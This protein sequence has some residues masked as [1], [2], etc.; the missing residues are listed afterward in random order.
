MVSNACVVK[1]RR[2]CL[3]PVPRLKISTGESRWELYVLANSLTD[4]AGFV[5]VSLGIV[6][7]EVLHQL[8]LQLL[9]GLKRGFIQEVFIEG[10]P[11]PPKSSQF[12]KCRPS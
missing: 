4:C 3:V 6:V 5:V 12:G 11:D 7:Q 8:I 2:V 1:A 10:A 9:H